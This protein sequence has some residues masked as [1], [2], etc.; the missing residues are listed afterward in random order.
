VALLG[1]HAALDSGH[2]VEKRYL[3][4]LYSVSKGRRSQIPFLSSRG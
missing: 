1:H 4:M 2:T 3:G